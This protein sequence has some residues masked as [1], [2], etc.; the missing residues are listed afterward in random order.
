MKTFF[1]G[2]YIKLI[3]CG[4]CKSAAHT[5]SFLLWLE[6]LFDERNKKKKNTKLV[7]LTKT[8]IGNKK[9]T[10]WISWRWVWP[11]SSEKWENSLG[12][13]KH[14]HGQRQKHLCSKHGWGWKKKL[15]QQ[16]TSPIKSFTAKRHR[17]IS[18]SRRL[19]VCFFL[20][21]RSV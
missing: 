21:S 8:N 2:N 9:K 20:L 11:S 13:N 15:Q 16:P 12:K 17:I 3:I 6:N 5:L 19:F 7:T 4:A 18:R 14:R 1:F 10:T